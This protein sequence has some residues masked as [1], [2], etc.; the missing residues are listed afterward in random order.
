MATQAFIG[1]Q[2]LIQVGNAASPEVF[3]TI[4]EVVSFGGMG[5]RNDLIEATHLLSLAKEYV[6][7]L[8]DGLEI[9]MSCNYVPNDTTQQTLLTAQANRITKNF[10]YIAPV[11]SSSPVKTFSF[12]ALVIGWETGETTPNTITHLNFTLKFSGAIILS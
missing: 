4:A 5:Q 7:G 8:A 12:A 9:T 3:S 10:K 11:G 2:T 1:S 6:Y